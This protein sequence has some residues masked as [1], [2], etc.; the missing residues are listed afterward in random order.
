MRR[1]AADQN[2]TLTLRSALATIDR[3]GPLTPSEL[4]VHEG[5]TTPSVTK[6]LRR[7]A[8]EG[9]IE[10]RP[11]P[12]D[13]RAYLVFVS[14]AGVQRLAG[15]RQRGFSYLETRMRRLEPEL[16]VV[17]P[18]VIAVLESLLEM[19]EDDEA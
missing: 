5:V 11:N 3:E 18:D 8:E 2:L 13:R 1:Y 19:G 15:A 4:A 16:L 14:A 9:L 7:L 10:R 6:I 12:R 17:V